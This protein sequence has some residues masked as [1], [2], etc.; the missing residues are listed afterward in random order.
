MN[1]CENCGYENKP[2][3]VFCEHYGHKL[4][5]QKGIICSNCHHLNPLN[6]DYCENCGT[7]LAKNGNVPPVNTQSFSQDHLDEQKRGDTARPVNPNNQGAPRNQA[8]Q[9]NQNN[10]G[11]QGNQFNQGNPSNPNNQFNQ[12]PNSQFDPATPNNQ[13]NQF[14]PGG[15]QKPHKKHGVL[16]AIIVVIVV[17]LIAGAVLFVTTSKTD[18]NSDKTTKSATPPTTQTQSPNK[19]KPTKDKSDD[20]KISL[21]S[22]KNFMSD[23]LGESDGQ[24]SAYFYDLNSDQHAQYGDDSTQ[25]AASNI[26]LFIMAAAYQ[27]VKDGELDLSDHYT[28]KDS[29]KVGGTGVVQQM[30][31]GSSISYHD[32]IKDMITQS[33]NTAANIMVDTIG[34]LDVVNDEISDLGLSDTTMERK[35][36]DTE[37]LEAGHD[38]M[39]TAHDLGIFMKKLYNHQ[40]VSKTYDED[41]LGILKDTSNHSKLPSQVASDITVYNK[42]GEYN[43]YG[44]QNDVAIFQKGDKAFV[45]SVMSEDGT[46]SDQKEA[47]GDLGSDLTNYILGDE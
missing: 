47:M 16:I 43:S 34:G 41:M 15:P 32:L 13:P 28:L 12:N 24:T 37:K 26:K 19:K 25:R 23:D 22:V 5:Q 42:T 11:N 36:M 2:N 38:N 14:G 39:T 30:E 21:A 27:K 10:M 31:T 35:L 18:Q 44:V 33:D 4:N 20:D 7:K 9:F 45:I 3:A 40:V 1:K 6:S 46:E 17:L 29:D 8:N